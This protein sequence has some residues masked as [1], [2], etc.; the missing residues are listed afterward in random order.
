MSRPVK[1]TRSELV[2]E[3]HIDFGVVDAKGRKVGMS[4]YSQIV[5]VS[6]DQQSMYALDERWAIGTNYT[7]I[8]QTTRDGAPFGGSD[9]RV[10]HPNQ[11]KAIRDFEFRVERARKAAVKKFG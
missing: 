7:L 3:R 10:M 5:E 2:K 11:N 6:E 8:G 1:Y 4:V 9:I